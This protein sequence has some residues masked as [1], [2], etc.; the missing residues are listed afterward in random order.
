MPN[1]TLFLVA[2]LSRGPFNSSWSGDGNLW[3]QDKL[4]ED[5]PVPSPFFSLIFKATILEIGRR[6]SHSLTWNYLLAD[7]R[8]CV[9]TRNTLR[10]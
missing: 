5:Y 10:S 6:E 2:V 8:F 7:T 9:G 1:A 4:G 3:K